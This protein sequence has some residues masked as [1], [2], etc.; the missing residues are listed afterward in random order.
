MLRIFKES[1]FKKEFINV[2][3]S[4]EEM[5]W[6][7]S[8]KEINELGSGDYALIKSINTEWKLYDLEGLAFNNFLQHKEEEK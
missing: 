4:N 6:G 7:F 8:L 5:F 3:L 1:E 2:I